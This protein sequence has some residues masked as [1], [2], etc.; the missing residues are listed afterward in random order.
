MITMA[1]FG[2]IVMY[3]MSML[4]LFKLRRSAP[5]MPRSF[6][7]PGYPIVPGIALLLS[8]VCLLAMLWFNPV[9]GAL[10]FAIMLVGYI[11]FLATKAQRDRAPQDTMLVGE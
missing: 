4:S 8:V 11:Y 10:F 6:H 5:E 1:V 9:I 2:A 3:I 7:A